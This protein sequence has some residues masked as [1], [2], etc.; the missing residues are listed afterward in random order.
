VGRSYQQLIS[1]WGSVLPTQSVCL[2]VPL[3]APSQHGGRH[4]RQQLA[5]AEQRRVAETAGEPE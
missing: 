2:T 1:D 5:E 4:F 3:L